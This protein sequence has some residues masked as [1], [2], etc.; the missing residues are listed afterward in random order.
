MQHTIFELRS[1]VVT[2]RIWALSLL[3]LTGA[4]LFDRHGAMLFDRYG[5]MLFDRY[6]CFA[7]HN[8]NCL[9]RDL[10]VQQY[11]CHM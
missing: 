3:E 4:M 6:G 10:P 2:G 1:K 5:A 7:L 8:F 11:F 9:L